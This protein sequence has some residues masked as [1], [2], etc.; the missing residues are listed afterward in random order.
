MCKHVH[1]QTFRLASFQLL[2]SFL[3]FFLLCLCPL[4]HTQTRTRTAH[5]SLLWPGSR[6]RVR[7][8]L[9][10]G[11]SPTW[12]CQVIHRG[13]GVWLHACVC[14][15]VSGWNGAELNDPNCG[16]NLEELRWYT[17]KNKKAGIGGRRGRD[18]EERARERKKV[19]K[20]E[21]GVG[22]GRQ[23]RSTVVIRVLKLISVV[24]WTR[25]GPLISAWHCCRLKAVTALCCCVCAGVRAHVHLRKKRGG[26]KVRKSVQMSFVS[27]Q[28]HLLCALYFLPYLDAIT[29]FA[30]LRVHSVPVLHA[31]VCASAESRNRLSSWLFLS[32]SD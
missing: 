9:G 13:G 2:A 14:V 7:V 19:G 30:S 11:V 21:E 10:N 1:T 20:G 25:C 5:I 23:T 32:V 8:Q 18:R 6:N 28:T 15:C 17:I 3:S 31:C 16:G 4:F 12:Q 24:F 22:G 29:I 27:E 26:E